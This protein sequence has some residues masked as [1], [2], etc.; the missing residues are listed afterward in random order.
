M[1]Q[2]P[3]A[4]SEDFQPHAKQKPSCAQGQQ[5]K[6]LPRHT[7]AVVDCLLQSQLCIFNTENVDRLQGL[8]TFSLAAIIA[9]AVELAVLLSEVHF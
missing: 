1:N 3:L 9:Q 2:H 8:G 4:V 7:T 5:R 6:P